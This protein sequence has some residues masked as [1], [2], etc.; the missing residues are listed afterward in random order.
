VH[1]KGSATCVR[2]HLAAVGWVLLA[3]INFKSHIIIPRVLIFIGWAYLF[4]FL[5]TTFSPALVCLKLQTH[6]CEAD[7]TIILQ[8]Q[9]LFTCDIP[10]FVRH[11]CIKS[12]SVTPQLCLSEIQSICL[13]DRYTV[14]SNK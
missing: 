14:L 4:V 2:R 12:I 11:E 8:I 13:N 1:Y 7:Q 5:C 9:R 6:C 3:L 10:L